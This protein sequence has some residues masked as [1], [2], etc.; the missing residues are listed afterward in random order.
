MIL[1]LTL[2]YGIIKFIDLYEGNDPNIRQSTKANFI[3]PKE[4]ITFANDLNFRMAVGVRRKGEQSL[5]YDPRVSRLFAMMTTYSYMESATSYKYFPMHDCT[6]ED[7][8]DFF[9]LQ[10]R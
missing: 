6:E 7:F 5:A 2:C 1:G 10:G 3:E 9:P 4:T 8:N